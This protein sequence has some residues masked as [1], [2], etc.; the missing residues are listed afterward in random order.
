MH[1]D[2]ETRF[3]Q[4]GISTWPLAAT[5]AARHESMA[6]MTKACAQTEP[7]NPLAPCETRKSRP[8][9]LQAAPISHTNKWVPGW[10]KDWPLKMVGPTVRAACTVPLHGGS[11]PNG[12]LG[13]AT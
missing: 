6:G 1:I 11:K 12:R 8:A 13:L 2:A 9:Q 4:D 10:V 3:L 5:K 7:P